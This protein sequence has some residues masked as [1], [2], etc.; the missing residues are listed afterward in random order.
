ML[1][2]YFFYWICFLCV[3]NLPF[4]YIFSLYVT[5]L[6]ISWQLRSI[7]ISSIKCLNFKMIDS[8]KIL[9]IDVTFGKNYIRD[10]LILTHLMKHGKL[11]QTKSIPSFSQKNKNKIHPLSS[12]LLNKKNPHKMGRDWLGEVDILP[13]LKL[14]R[15]LI[16]QIYIFSLT[17]C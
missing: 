1:K 7:T 9:L 16:H 17:K 4:D 2:L 8:I 15:Y 14:E 5:C 3:T 12:P 6:Q 13:P 11:E 10:N